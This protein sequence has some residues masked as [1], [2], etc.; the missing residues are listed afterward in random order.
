MKKS[1]MTLV[2]FLYSFSLFCQTNNEEQ[3]QPSGYS[4]HSKGDVSISLSGN[5]LMND[6]YESLYAG[7]FKMR[8][9]VS[10][11]LSFDADLVIGKDYFHLGPGLIGLPLWIL[12]NGLGISSDEDQTFTEFLILIT[13]MGLSAE[14]IAYH[15]PLKNTTDISPFVSFLRFN[16]IDIYDPNTKTE[17]YYSHTCFVA[18]VEVNKYFKRFVLS[19]YIEYNI[20][21]SGDFHGFNFGLNFGY[22]FP[23]KR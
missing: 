15:I 23:K 13:L 18:G 7:G 21:Y 8:M 14:H 3:P 22:Y 12:G 4:T 6:P 2:M 10:N 20:A 9:F 11:R 16:E 19:P 1:L 5:R 17:E